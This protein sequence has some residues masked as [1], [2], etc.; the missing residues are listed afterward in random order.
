MCAVVLLQRLA[1]V[2]DAPQK[3]R[4][5]GLVQKLQTMGYKVSDHGDLQFE[6]T[7]KDPPSFNIKGP[8][9]I[10]AAVNKI[11]NKV[12]N[13]IRSGDTCLSLGGDHAMSIGTVHGHMLVEPN[14]KLVWVDAHA[15]INPPLASTSG[16]IHGMVLSF[17]VHELQEFIPA[18]PGFDWLKPCIHAKDLTFIGLRDIDPAERYIIEKLGIRCYTMHDVDARGISDVVEE[19]I[20][21]VNPNLEC[22]M[23]LSFDIDALDPSLA[24]S[25]GTP[26]A[27]GLTVRE[28]M[29]IAE[30]MAL[31]G[32]LTG[33]D[34]VEVNTHLG[35][36][37]DQDLTLFTACELL[38]ACFGKRR[39]GNIPDNFQLA[40]P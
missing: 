14:T 18:V 8:R 21:V 6:T 35:T 15:D 16:N 17:L 39:M 5:A 1:G 20:R 34:L 4:G 27:G 13:V 33:V 37:R 12:A 7:T 24:P 3:L 10:G 26:V 31:T 19:A 11:S 22:P 2:E 30:E 38:L 9:T 29:Y 25:T 40:R 23:H 32:K 28:G 36:K